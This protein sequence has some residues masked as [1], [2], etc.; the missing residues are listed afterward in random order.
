MHD[1]PGVRFNPVR[2]QLLPLFSP[3]AVGGGSP[4]SPTSPHEKDTIKMADTG[5][6]EQCVCVS[7]V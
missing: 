5:E 2:T 7:Q 1:M 3:A 6:A 4:L